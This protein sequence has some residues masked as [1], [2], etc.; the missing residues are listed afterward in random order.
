[1]SSDDTPLHAMA[2]TGKGAAG[3]EDTVDETTPLSPGDDGNV[4]GG[5]QLPL[6][7]GAKYGNDQATRLIFYMLMA[8]TEIVGIVA[9]VL[10]IIW[11]SHFRGGFAWD[12]SGKEFNY[13]PI[14]MVVGMVVLYGNGRISLLS[15]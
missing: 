13:H 7:A 2:P 6:T 1:M 8:G 4:V 3:Q 9:V 14:F 5:G 10:V 12:G 11:M 15:F